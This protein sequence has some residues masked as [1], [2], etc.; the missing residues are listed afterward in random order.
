MT[1]DTDHSSTQLS[2]DEQQYGDLKLPWGLL[3]IVE[4][5]GSSRA[6]AYLKWLQGLPQ[7]RRAYYLKRVLKEQPHRTKTSYKLGGM[8]EW[9]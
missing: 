4:T 9:I 5:L 1:T 3:S 8:R 6:R 2:E 7:G